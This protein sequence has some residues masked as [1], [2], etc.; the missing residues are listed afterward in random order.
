MK[1]IK[2]SFSEV[3]KFISASALSREYFGKERAWLNNKLCERTING[4]RY[5]FSSDECLILS[6]ALSD[7][8]SKISSVA[9]ELQTTAKHL[10]KSTGRFF[11]TKANPFNHPLFYEWL[12]LL[13]PKSVVVEPFAGACD[14]PRLLKDIGFNPPWKCYDISSPMNKRSGFHVTKRDCIINPPKGSVFITNP[15]Y[16]AKN[17][18]KRNHYPYPQT[19]FSNL[20]LHCLSTMLE[21]GKYVAAILPESFI[22]DKVFKERLF[23]VISINYKVFNGTDYP[24]CLALFTPEKRGDYPIYSG[25][26]L[27]GTYKELVDYSYSGTF[28]G[29]WTFNSPDGSVG[30]KC[31]DGLVADIRFVRGEMIDSSK[32]KGSSRSLTRVEGLP[33]DIDRDAFIDGCNALL[34]E[35]RNKTKDIFMTAFKGLRKDNQYRRRIDFATVRSIMNTTLDTMRQDNMI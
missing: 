6:D 3:E 14:I 12:S 8:A 16:L 20:Y 15:P 1:T 11:T 18:A 21:N 31:Y 29:N 24:V 22:S 10:D 4:V 35:Y 5:H 30:I 2:E 19:S 13:P 25:N 26:E 23:G 32:I 28:Q 17:S 33:A 7:I 34:K 27:L 9:E